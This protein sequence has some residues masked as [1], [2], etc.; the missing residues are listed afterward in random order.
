MSEWEN[1]ILTTISLFHS[2]VVYVPNIKQNLEARL[3]IYNEITG[4]QNSS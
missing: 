4:L 3:F 1:F 2:E